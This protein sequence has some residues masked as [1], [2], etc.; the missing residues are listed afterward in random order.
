M[1]MHL[2]LSYNPLVGPDPQSENHWG[3]VELSSLCYP[4]IST[5]PTNGSLVTQAI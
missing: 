5:I 1:G 2:K 3:C 4:S